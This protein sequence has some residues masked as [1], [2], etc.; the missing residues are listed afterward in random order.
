MM[1]PINQISQGSRHKHEAEDYRPVPIAYWIR[2]LMRVSVL[3]EIGS[4][5][6]WISFYR[7]EIYLDNPPFMVYK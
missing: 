5:P 3:L 4:V 1:A 7:E 2:V 6:A